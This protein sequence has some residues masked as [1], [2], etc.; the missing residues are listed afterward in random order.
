MNND[1]VS[2][3][4]EPWSLVEPCGAADKLNNWSRA[5][6]NSDALAILDG[7]DQLR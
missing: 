1:F 3:S 6:A 4:A 7:L 2:Q 5:P